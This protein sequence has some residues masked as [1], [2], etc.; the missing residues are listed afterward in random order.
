MSPAW[1][2]IAGV[3]T[4]LLMLIFIGIWIWAWRPRH[5]AKFDAMAR[6]PMTDD[7]EP[8]AGDEERPR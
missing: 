4:I 2:P 7:A 6:L 8:A 5:R 3:I 1:G